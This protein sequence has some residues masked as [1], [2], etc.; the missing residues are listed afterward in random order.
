MRVPHF[1]P[2]LLYSIQVKEELVRVGF[3]APTVLGSPVRENLQEC[4]SQG[5]VEE[6]TLSL[7]KSAAVKTVFS[8][9]TLAKTML[10]WASIPVN[11]A[12]AFTVADITKCLDPAGNLDAAS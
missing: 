8:G 3:D 4:H 11:L 1:R 10:A 2:G 6:K 12:D 5:I 7:R 9:Y